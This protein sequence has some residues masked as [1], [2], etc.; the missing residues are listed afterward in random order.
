M[1]YLICGLFHVPL[2]DT[3]PEGSFGELLR[4]DEE[5]DTSLPELSLLLSFVLLLL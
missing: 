3:F 1:D 4:D 5:G 2:G